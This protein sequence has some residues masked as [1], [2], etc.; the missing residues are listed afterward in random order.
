MK[1]LRLPQKGLEVPTF[2][3]DE[4]RPSHLKTTWKN[5]TEHGLTMAAARLFAR[6]VSD[7]SLEKLHK[8]GRKNLRVWVY[9]SELRSRGPSLS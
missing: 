1:T 3:T 6:L 8:Q 9:V 4:G 7:K 5:Q 2:E